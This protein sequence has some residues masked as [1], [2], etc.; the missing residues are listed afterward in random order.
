MTI[1]QIAQI[2]HETNRTYCATLGD[3]SQPAWRDAPD[4][5]QTSAINGVKFHLAYPDAGD[6]ASHDSWLEEKRRTGWTYGSVKNPEKK[7]HPCFVPFTA[8]PAEQQVKDALFRSIVHATQR[9]LPEQPQVQQTGLPAKPIEEVLEEVSARLE[10]MKDV[11]PHHKEAHEHV[12]TAL[13]RLN[14]SPKA[15]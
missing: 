5:Q 7:T 14:E 12:R 10:C 15:A 4:W 6:S 2:C 1:D 13:R 3:T 9:L 8:L 11:T